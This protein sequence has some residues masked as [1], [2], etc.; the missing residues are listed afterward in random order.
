M[1]VKVSRQLGAVVA[2]LFL[3]MAPP[4]EAVEDGCWAC[5]MC[6]P[7]ESCLSCGVM[8]LNAIS[9]CCGMD[10]GQTF[11]VPDYGGFAV[12]CD[13]GRACQCNMA[14]DTCDPLE[15]SGG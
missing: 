1:K 5:S 2:L 15:M 12:N 3:L 13:S 6:Y 9:G 7:D 11:C 8:A 10:G 14:G 4:A